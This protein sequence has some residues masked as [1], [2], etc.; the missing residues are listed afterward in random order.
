MS[1]SIHPLFVC[2]CHGKLTYE[3]LNDDID[4]ACCWHTV[5]FNKS[6]KLTQQFKDQSLKWMIH[7]RQLHEQDKLRGLIL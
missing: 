2:C 4:K 7:F 1:S 3:V 5:G 6:R